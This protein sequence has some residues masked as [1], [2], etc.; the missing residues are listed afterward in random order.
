MARICFVL[1]ITPWDDR[2]QFHRQ[3]PALAADGHE[4]LYLA[5][6]GTP[7]EPPPFRMLSLS[8]RELR[9]SR[10]TGA[11]NLYRRIVREAPDVVHLCSLELL[12]LGLALKATTSIRVVY[13]CR[14]DMV[15]SMRHSKLRFPSWQREFL[16]R[17]TAAVERAAA[18]RFDGLITADPAT[19]ELHPE[20]P[21]NR[22]MVFY[23]T[24]NLSFFP[25]D[26]P[27]L[28]ERDFDLV[29]LGGTK[30]RSGIFVLAE[31]LGTLRAEGRR[32][33]ALVVGDLDPEGREAFEKQVFEFGVADDV[34]V[35]GRVPHPDVPAWLRRGRVGLVLLLADPK[36][37]RN[38][39]CKAFEYMAAGMPVVSSDLAPERIFLR[40]G[41]NGFL[42]PPGDVSALSARVRMLLDDPSL[43]KKLGDRGRRDV[44]QEWNA[45]AEMRK[46]QQFYREVVLGP[47]R[48]VG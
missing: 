46:L 20:M 19:G 37:D 36:F 35:T 47:P 9:R 30:P 16:A 7:A 12:P 23:N 11:L 29:L 18:R 42:F 5:G 8:R 13:D 38:I 48:R 33:R 27:P 15:S 34:V 24:A 6:E 26:Y 32:L 31:L 44:E 45:E 39:A 4:V 43:A 1:T 25:A 3:A 14:E 22:R 17:A 41:E 40:D 10:P 21:P 28:A 2:R